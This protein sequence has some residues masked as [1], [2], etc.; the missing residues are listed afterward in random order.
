[1]MHFYESTLIDTVDGLQCKSYANEHPPGYIIVKPKYIPKDAIEGEGLRYRFLF[2]K[3]LVRFNL[4]TEKEKLRNYV[5][6]FRKTFP[7][8]IYHSKIHKNWFFA[9]PR[10]K[11]KAIHDC[12][13]GLQELLKVPKKDLDKYL[14]LVVELVGFLCKSGIRAKDLGITHST[15]LG[16]YTPGKSDIDIV[17]YGK[18]NGWEILDYLKSAKHP[19]LRWKSDEEWAQYYKEH[20]TAESSHF[21]EEEYVKHMA[22]KRYEGTFGGNVFTLFTVEE[23]NETWFKWGEETYEP[24]GIATIKGKVTD[25]YN[26]HVRPGFYE[27]ASGEL[28]EAPPARID[29][30]IPIKRVVTYSIPFVQQAVTGETITACGLLELV[31]RKK[32][33]P[34]YR[35]V[36]GYFDAYTTERREKEFIKSEVE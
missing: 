5:E 30:R 21:T 9:V 14:G 24:L 6:Q 23:P 36:V 3:C 18:K 26:S 31:R 27:I 2:E 1:M 19:L 12:R 22:R 10:E 32:G 35:I 13:K 8:Y 20:K 15:L 17:I 33:K 16:N 11:I 29:K 4:F 28:I 25:H 7:D 34:Y